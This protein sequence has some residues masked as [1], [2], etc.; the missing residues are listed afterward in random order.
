MDRVTSGTATSTT[1]LDLLNYSL[2]NPRIRTVREDCHL[3]SNLEV[4]DISP[5]GR[6]PAED[7]E[8][9]RDPQLLEK[10]RRG[11][12]LLLLYESRLATTPRTVVLARRGL[13]KFFDLKLE[14]LAEDAE[15]ALRPEDRAVRDYVLFEAKRHL[16]RRGC[17]EV[18]KTVKANG[19]NA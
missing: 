5:L 19:E 7:K 6:G 10:V 4:L 2:S 12:T 17:V 15:R 18:F 9:A 8:F 3:A 14:Y 1:A 11:N 16:A 13:K